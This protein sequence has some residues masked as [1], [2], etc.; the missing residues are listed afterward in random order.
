MH[1]DDEIPEADNLAHAARRALRRLTDDAPADLSWPAVQTRAR[2]VQ[3]TRAAVAI[4]AVAVVLAGIG[5]TVAAANRHRDHLSI[6]G[7]GNTSTSTSEASSST[8]TSPSP[9]STTSRSGL[10]SNDGGGR[11]TT[12]ATPGDVPLAQLDDLQGTLTVPP[13]LVAG[14]SAPFTLTVRNVTDHSI[15]WPFV[16]PFGGPILGL[17]TDGVEPA[18]RTAAPYVD[19]LQ[20]HDGEQ[21]LLAAGQTQTFT[22][23]IN[24]YPEQIGPAVVSLELITINDL[25]H[26]SVGTH[27]AMPGVPSV[28]VTILPPGWTE[29][30]PLDPAQ[31]KWTA[32][33]STGATDVRIGDTVTVF[34]TLRND[35]D[36]PQQTEGYGKLAIVCDPATVDPIGAFITSATVEAGTDQTFSVEITPPESFVGTVTCRVGIAFYG[37]AND[38]PPRPGIDSDSV[39]F[40]VLPASDTTT[41]SGPSTPTTVP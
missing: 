32:R 15:R 21:F 11:G 1:P 41:T 6:A 37:Y 2:R 20:V 23:Q 8:T 19:V 10:P 5:G 25:R 24:A 35:G 36:R 29:G 33:M 30:Q 7:G 3:R 9:T 38:A 40:T 18:N 4:A 34:A 22:S 39:N 14:S 12:P 31:G 17:W 26:G 27:D 13:T 28:P 16:A